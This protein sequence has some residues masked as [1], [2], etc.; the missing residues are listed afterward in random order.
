MRLRPSNPSCHSEEQSDE[1]PGFAG[2]PAARDFSNDSSTGEGHDFQSCRKESPKGVRL[3]PLG[4]AATPY[5]S[6]TP[7]P[8]QRSLRHEW[9]SCPS[10]FCSALA[11]RGQECPRHKPRRASLGGQPGGCPHM[12]LGLAK[13]QELTA[14]SAPH[15]HS[16]VPGGFDVMS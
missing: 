2:L 16:I 11:I 14:K 12:I 4:F 15:S 8:S 9:N 3:Q 13:S 6:A 7:V 1:E 5:P 10:R